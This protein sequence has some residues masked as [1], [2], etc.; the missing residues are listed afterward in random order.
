[1]RFLMAF[2]AK[3]STRKRT[4]RQRKAGDDE[5]EA[6]EASRPRKST[7]DDDQGE[8]DAVEE[9]HLPSVLEDIHDLQKMRAKAFGLSA[10]ELALG[11]EI[12]KA[13][14]MVCDDPFKMKTGGIVHVKQL[15][16]SQ[17]DAADIEDG[18]K[19]Q[20]S[21]ESHL[22]DEDEEMRKFVEEEMAKRSGK[23]VR[24][25]Q[26]K[27]VIAD[28]F[29]SPEEQLMQLAADK[30]KRFK[31]KSC[32]EMLSSTMLSGIP[33]VDLGISNRMTNIE[34]TE[35]KKRLM[36]TEVMQKKRNLATDNMFK[37]ESMKNQSQKY[38]QHAIFYMEETT[39]LGQ[40]DWRDKK[41]IALAQTPDLR[42]VGSTDDSE[43]LAKD[44]EKSQ[45]QKKLQASSAVD[46]IK[47][48]VQA[49]K[50]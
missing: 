10:A 20:F 3:S 33:E 32:A 34:E 48:A 28:T 30:L 11:K 50:A 24:R 4:Y 49:K 17:L 8:E 23:V 12:P 36:L 25:D 14:Q 21:K 13:L 19:Q 29:T 44:A 42:V 27:P 22:R 46:K 37:Q 7:D 43:D 47:K 18:I 45:A 15:R 41:N 26:Y 9:K 2:F 40:D 5:D 38:L 16:R 39:D 1:L 35:R 6:G 31:S